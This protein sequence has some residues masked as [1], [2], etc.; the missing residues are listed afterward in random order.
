[1]L[2]IV[3]RNW[4][5]FDGKHPLVGSLRLSYALGRYNTDGVGALSGN[6][7]GFDD[8]RWQACGFCA[9]GHCTFGVKVLHCSRQGI[10]AEH[11]LVCSL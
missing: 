10:D 2:G 5:G 11:R 8:K 4:L 1:M 9:P 7:R 6:R 3:L